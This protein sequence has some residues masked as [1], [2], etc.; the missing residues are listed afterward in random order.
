MNIA[1][2][3][4]GNGTN[5]QAIIEAVK[6]GFIPAKIALVV[7]DNGGAY[8]LTRA[9]NAGI[10]T[11]V[12]NPKDYPVREAFDK[13]VIKNLSKKE[14][15]LVVLAGFMRLLSPYFI[16]EYRNRIMN[17]H[18][19]LLPSFK[20]T[21]G[22]KDALE[23]GVKITGPTVHFVDDKL[24]HGPIILQSAVEVKDDDTEETLLGRIHQEEHKIYPQA[25]KLFV[26]GRVKIEG[27]RVKIT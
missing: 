6:T 26:E 3:C 27:R 1:V 9:K 21:R 25:I 14:V 15:G 23:Y 22:V 5:L 16:N 18:P 7:S 13:E 17:I 2:L 10:E 24:D 4:S 12:L 8:A 20:G 19:A 11:L